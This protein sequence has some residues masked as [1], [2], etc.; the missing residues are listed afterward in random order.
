MLAAFRTAWTSEGERDRGQPV[1]DRSKPG[2]KE[3]AL[4]EKQTH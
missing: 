4:E 2:L 3:T 1:L